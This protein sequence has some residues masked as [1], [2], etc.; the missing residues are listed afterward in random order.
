[1]LNGCFTCC[2]FLLYLFA[3]SNVYSFSSRIPPQELPDFYPSEAA[4]IPL[5]VDK[6]ILN[7]ANSFFFHAYGVDLAWL[8]NCRPL[9]NYSV[10]GTVGK[11]Y[12]YS[13]K[14]ISCHRF[15]T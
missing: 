7:H 8:F 12:L 3:G 5:I 13:G 10:L 15:Y 11:R 4:T 2:L 1:M 6:Q 9:Y 14:Y